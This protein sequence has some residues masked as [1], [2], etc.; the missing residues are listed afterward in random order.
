V[1]RLIA[2]RFPRGG[3]LNHDDGAWVWLFSGVALFR[4]GSFPVCVTVVVLMMVTI[5]AVRL[6]QGPAVAEAPR[7]VLRVPPPTL[8]GG[9]CATHP[10]SRAH[11]RRDPGRRR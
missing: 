7:N 2:F 10:V 9:L 4:C 1:V 6:V 3:L 8:F 5:V 11:A